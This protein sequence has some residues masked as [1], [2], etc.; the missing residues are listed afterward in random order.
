MTASTRFF[1]RHNQA[2]FER[3]SIG[4]SC[5]HAPVQE[6]PITLRIRPND[7]DGKLGGSH[8]VITMSVDEAREAVRLL[9]SYVEACEKRA[10]AV[11]S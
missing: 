5:T 7:N 9:A 10:E 3:V 1:K 2:T 6:E 8:F 4:Y 11:A